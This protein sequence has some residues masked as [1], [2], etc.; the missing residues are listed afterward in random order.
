MAL[1]LSNRRSHSQTLG[2]VVILDK[3]LSVKA[4]NAKNNHSQRKRLGW[5]TH[6]TFSITKSY[7]SVKE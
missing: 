2:Q 1:Y 4:P 7:V 6:V 5:M 3:I